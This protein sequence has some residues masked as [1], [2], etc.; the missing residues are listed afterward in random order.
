MRAIL[1]V[2][3]YRLVYRVP[4]SPRVALP[5]TERDE[6]FRSGKIMTLCALHTSSLL[7]FSSTTWHCISA[8]SLMVSCLVDAIQATV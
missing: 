5:H 1:F 3:A 6:R 8:I 4:P 7:Q 2:T